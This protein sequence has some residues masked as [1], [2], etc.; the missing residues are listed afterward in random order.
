LQNSSGGSKRLLVEQGLEP[1]LERLLFRRHVRLLSRVS[2]PVVYRV[3]GLTGSTVRPNVAFVTSAKDAYHAT[4]AVARPE[5]AAEL[6]DAGVRAGVADAERE[7]RDRQQREH[8]RHG[9]RRAQR[10]DEHVRGEDAPRDQVE[11]DRVAG[12]GLRD[13]LL[14]ELHERPE[15][16]PERAVGRER[17]RAERIA[18]AELPHPGQHLGEPAVG[19][20]HAE[21]DRLAAPRPAGVEHA[22]DER[23]RRECGEPERAGIRDRRRGDGCG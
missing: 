5:P 16:Q 2:K 4:T 6:D 17:G 18:G 12:V 9:G 14:E 7:E 11:A 20:R 1:L 23:R 15:R 22:E 3:S 13:V 10:R 8:E 19:E 21:H